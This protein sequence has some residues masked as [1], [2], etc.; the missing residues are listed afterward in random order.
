MPDSKP[1]KPGKGL[2]RGKLDSLVRR[3]KGLGSSDA[4]QDQAEDLLASTVAVPEQYYRFSKMPQLVEM[5]RAKAVFDALGFQNPFFRPHSGV[6]GATTRMDGEDYLNFATYN[7]LGLNGHPEVSTAAHAAIDQYG[8]SASGSRIISGNKEVHLELEQAIADMIGVDEA[9][10][11]VSGHATN[12]STIGYLVGPRDLVIQDALA[13]NSVTQG[14]LLSGAHRM[15]FP[16]NDLEAL[17][18]MLVE[19]RG[20]FERVLVAVEGH[21]GMDGDV[22]DLPGLLALRRKHRFL[23]MVDEAHSIG[24]LGATGRGIGEHFG[25]DPN[26][27][28][29]WM[30]TLSKALAGCGGYI[31]GCSDLIHMIAYR[32]PGTVYSVGMPPAM[33]AASLTC[34]RLMQREPERIRKLN[35]NTRLF[36]ERARAAGLNTGTA[37]PH[38]IVPVITGSSRKAA[39]LCNRLYAKKINV[40]PIVAPAVEEGQSR[41]R[42]FL[43]ALH[44]DEQ[45]VRAVDA[46]KEQYPRL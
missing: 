29:I 7:Y 34:I 31:A 12:V 3:M 46:V 2:G 16:H 15:S 9:H 32:V 8:T 38:A 23:L 30:G 14:A 44:T 40:L 43:S 11:F 20:R 28:D 1:G 41:L 26:D 27:V 6:A 17:D 18:R 22:P 35:E 42:F 10:C 39:Q 36:L 5:R 13:H 45:I 37:G 24:V 25:I 33:A 19:V 21:Y 4:P